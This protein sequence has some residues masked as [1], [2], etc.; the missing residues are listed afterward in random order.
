MAS[1]FYAIK[2]F[3]QLKGKIDPKLKNDSISKTRSDRVSTIRLFDQVH[4]LVVK[5][6]NPRMNAQRSLFLVFYVEYM[7]CLSVQKV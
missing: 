7:F 3:M 6:H 5:F 4:H 2:C 1:T